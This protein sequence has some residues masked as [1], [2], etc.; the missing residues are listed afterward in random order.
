MKPVSEPFAFS[1]SAGEILYVGSLIKPWTL[2]IGQ[3]PKN[4]SDVI[5]KDYATR[6]LAGSGTPVPLMVANEGENI[7]Y[8]FISRHPSL[9]GE[10]IRIRLLQ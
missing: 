5:F 2:T 1:I 9:D 7:F 6:S 4:L 3:M 8:Q 10:S